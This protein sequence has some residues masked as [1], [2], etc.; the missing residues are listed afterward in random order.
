MLN[1]YRSDQGGIPLAPL[2]LGLAGVV[3]FAIAAAGQSLAFPALLGVEWTIVALVYCATI[4]PFMAGCIWAFAARHD[5]PKGVAL[6]TLPA[7]AG[8]AVLCLTYAQP[9][10]PQSWSI[11]F[12]TLFALLLVL[13]FRAHRLGQTPAWWM[14]LRLLL[15]TLVTGCLL[16]IAQMS[17]N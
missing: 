6:S 15:T 12:A 9:N 16:L 2:V 11:P 7:L 17:P 5:D 4:L 13:D 3:P 10:Q 8:F 1:Q 14:R